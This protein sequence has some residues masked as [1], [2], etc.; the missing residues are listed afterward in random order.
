MRTRAACQLPETAAFCHSAAEQPRQRHAVRCFELLFHW[1]AHSGSPGAHH[2]GVSAL[3]GV[4]LRKRRQQLLQAGRA[5]GGWGGGQAW[6]IRRA[7]VCQPVCHAGAWQR[8]AGMLPKAGTSSQH[9]AAPLSPLL[10]PPACLCGQLAIC[11]CVQQ[12]ESVPGIIL[13]SLLRPVLVAGRIPH[14]ELQAR[15][16][17][18][19]VH[20]R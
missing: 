1:R 20:S 18:A 4:Q 17:N 9:S 8:E 5:Q 15:A 7:S 13:L 3:G 12:H 6:V 11:I 19:L 14:G 10:V 16:G 2:A